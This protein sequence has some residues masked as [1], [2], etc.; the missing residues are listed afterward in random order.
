MDVRNPLNL[1]KQVTTNNPTEYVF[2]TM[3]VQTRSFRT[4]PIRVRSDF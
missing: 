2:S 3:D 1:N 4:Y